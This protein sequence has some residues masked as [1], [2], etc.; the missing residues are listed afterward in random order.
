MKSI[1]RFVNEQIISIFMNEIEISYKSIDAN[2]CHLIVFSSHFNSCCIWF[3][4]IESMFDQ[5]LEYVI[6]R[7]WK[8]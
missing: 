5:I 2:N 3:H 1:P 8:H 4:S 7:L 6:V